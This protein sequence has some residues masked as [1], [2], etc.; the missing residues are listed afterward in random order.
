MDYSEM[1]TNQLEQ[2][3]G[4]VTR[5]LFRLKSKPDSPGYQE[6][7]D[8][9]TAMRAEMEAELFGRLGAQT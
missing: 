6:T 3:I 5:N 8:R 1:T 9:L 4:G 7:H 2:S